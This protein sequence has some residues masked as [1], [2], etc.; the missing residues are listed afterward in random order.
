MSGYVRHNSTFGHC[1][2]VS[3]REKKLENARG[4]FSVYFFFLFLAGTGNIN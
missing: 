1:L 3:L 2:S 4:Y